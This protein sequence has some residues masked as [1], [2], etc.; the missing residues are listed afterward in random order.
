MKI[1]FSRLLAVFACGLAA[2]AFGFGCRSYVDVNG[3]SC[4]MLTE[5][6]IHELVTIARATMAKNSPRHATAEEVEVIRS[7]KPTIKIQYYG[8]CL[9]EAVI[10]WDLKTRKIEVVFDGQLNSN[11]PMERDIMLRVMKKQPPVLD[12]RPEQ[13]R[14]MQGTPQLQP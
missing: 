14:R 6:E 9:A 1:S 4:A 5:R 8:N 3:R 7:T 2:L 12:F 13:R 11:D 10:A